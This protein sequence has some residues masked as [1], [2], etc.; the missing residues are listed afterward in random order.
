MAEC[1]DEGIEFS[2]LAVVKDPYDVAV[3]RLVEN[4]KNI[5]DLVV[6]SER[7]G[8]N[9]ASYLSSK[10]DFDGPDG[11]HAITLDELAAAAERKSQLSQVADGF[12]AAPLPPHCNINVVQWEE[13][14]TGGHVGLQ[15]YTADQLEI[16]IAEH[17]ELRLAAHSE[18]VMR[19]SDRIKATD[20]RNDYGP[21][22]QTWLKLL[23]ERGLVKDMTR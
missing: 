20:R 1:E 12:Q 2:L 3:S 5:R 17:T 22:L 13:C 19:D 14:Q 9:L 8:A 4:V 18:I 21:F 10:S 23:A 7:N 16:L 15:P 11:T 6:K